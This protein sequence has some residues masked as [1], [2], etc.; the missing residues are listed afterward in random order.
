MHSL[1]VCYP[2][3]WWINLAPNMNSTA[4][5]IRTRIGFPTGVVFTSPTGNNP[6]VYSG[7]EIT[8]KSS[9]TLQLIQFIAKV[10][11]LYTPEAL[12]VVA[13]TAFLQLQHC[14]QE[15]RYEPMKALIK[16][17]NIDEESSAEQLRWFYGKTRA[18]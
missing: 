9:K 14:W 5:R 17:E 10:D 4:A 6:Y 3:V 1:F 16:E 2:V 8:R 7:S 15:R 13:K 18:S 12:V 11:P